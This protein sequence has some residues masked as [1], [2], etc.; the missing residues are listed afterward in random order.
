MTPTLIET[1]LIVAILGIIIFLYRIQKQLLKKGGDDA[2]TLLQNDINN[3]RESIQKNLTTNREELG[4]SLT[5]QAGESQKL[6]R[7]VIKEVERVKSTSTEILSLKD[8][9]QNLQRVLTN[10]R[11]RGGL[12]EYYLEAVLKNILPPNTFEYQYSFK[13][14]QRVDA[15]IHLDKCF[16][17]IDSKFSLDNYIKLTEAKS[18]EEKIMAERKLKEDIKRRIDETAKYILPRE[19]TTDFAFMFIPSETL[20]YDLL[21]QRIGGINLLTYAYVEKKVIIVS[22][23]TFSA[24]L[25]TILQGLR[26]LDIEERATAIIKKLG[27]LNKKLESYCDSF[28]SVGKSLDATVG[29]YNKAHKQFLG[30]DKN[31]RALT[32]SKGNIELP[33]TLSK[34]TQE[35]K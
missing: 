19:G 21:T 34:T 7:E 29:H 20:Y 23:T 31:I 26:S 32:G 4:R 24:Y 18:K 35:E 8:P 27:A 22:P 3:F 10:P 15:I 25:Q 11:E 13:D 2:F 9:I 30:I 16:L 17:P 14:N 5:E 12:G 6:I 28:S 1:F 33:D